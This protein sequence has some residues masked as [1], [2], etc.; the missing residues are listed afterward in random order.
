[1]EKLTVIIP[2]GNEEKNIED[3]LKSASF[4]DEIMVVDSFSTDRT[5]EIAQKYTGFILQHEYIHSAAQKNWAIPQANNEWIFV[6][7]SDERITPELASEI[8]QILHK[9]TNKAG[10]WVYRNNYFMGRHLK[11]GGWNRDKV[12]RLFRKSM[13]RYKDKH[14]HAE[15]ETEGEVGV[16]NA[17]LIHDTYTGFDKYVEKVNRYS[18]W[19]AKDYNTKVKRLTAYHFFVKPFWRF[20]HHY[21]VR[22]GFRDGVPGLTVA[23]LAGYALFTRYLK[24]W[25]LRQNS[26]KDRAYF[27]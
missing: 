17:K 14:V 21:I 20:F 18:W 4:A 25:L 11:H 26:E 10:F 16:M 7:D 12:I 2:A 6:L 8:K 3:A 13:C 27:K 1:M 22:G 24:L 23:T 19:Q 15:I 5:V 9:G